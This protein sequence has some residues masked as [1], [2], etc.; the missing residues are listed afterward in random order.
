M[1]LSLIK[2]QMSGSLRQ[3]YLLARYAT[4]KCLMAKNTSATLLKR[5]SR[6]SNLFLL[7]KSASM[8][9]RVWKH[10][11]FTSQNTE[12]KKESIF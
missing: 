2:I 7:A 6:E 5:K 11:R 9:F 10:L 8:I 4:K 3:A 1:I 12:S